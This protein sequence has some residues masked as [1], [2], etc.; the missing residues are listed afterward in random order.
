MNLQL[1]SLL[2]I[3][4][5]LIS[6]LFSICLLPTV[7]LR[8]ISG[9][10]H[11][12]GGLGHTLRGTTH[13]SSFRGSGSCL[14]RALIG[15]FHN[16][17]IKK[18][19]Y[20]YIYIHTWSMLEFHDHGDPGFSMQYCVFFLVMLPGSIKKWKIQKK[21][22]KNIKSLKSHGKSVFQ[23]IATFYLLTLHWYPFCVTFNINTWS[24]GIYVHGCSF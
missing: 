3:F 23:G 7:M 5:H 6:S 2:H 18:Y 17:Y 10:P 22:Y 11:L 19:I 13:F 1:S 24:H 8:R 12:S 15:I 16:F 4:Y 14:P 21:A 20:I 9:H